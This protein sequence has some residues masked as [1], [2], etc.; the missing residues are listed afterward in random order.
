MSYKSDIVDSWFGDF[1]SH[2]Y[3][4]CSNFVNLE[5]YQPNF[6]EVFIKTCECISRGSV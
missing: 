4:T 3:P 5:T 2:V 1:G 6:L